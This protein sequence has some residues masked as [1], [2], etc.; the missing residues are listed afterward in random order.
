MGGISSLLGAVSLLGFLLF[1]AGIG[2]VVV[3]ASQGRPVRGGVLLSILG[4]VLGILLSVVG[5]GILIVEP[6]QRAVVFQTLSGVLEDPR[7]PGTHIIIPVLQQ[8]TI[9]DV[10]SREYTMSGSTNEG[11]VQGNDAVRVRT[12]DGQE[13]L[14]DV[15]VI[16]RITPV[17]ITVT[18]E[19]GN[20][21]GDI[22]NVNTVHERWQNRY[23]Q[24]FIRPVTRGL[25]RDVVSDVDAEGIYSTDRTRIQIAI[26]TQLANLMAVEGLDLTDFIIREITFSNQDFADSIERVLIAERA[27]QEAANRARQEEEEANRVRIRAQGERDA[28]ILRAEGEAQ[29]IVLLA[30][31][32]AEALRLVSEQI[33][34]NPA[35]IQYEYIR[36]LS[37]NINIA[38]V[39]SNSPFLF[40]FDSFTAN[41]DFVA[42]TVPDVNLPSIQEIAPDSSGD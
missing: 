28:E 35:L 1:L 20:P 17:D 30:Q 41:P 16:Y 39:P 40:D 21:T 22:A 33:A 37:D 7:G 24:D 27:V 36:S 13:V 10:S 38:L 19:N 14:I 23:E 8:P 12:V 6:Q 11:A 2:L 26:Q 31:A 29:G 4:L 5:Q 25:V 9:Y 3:S 34:A 18:D 42:P 15:T 32:N